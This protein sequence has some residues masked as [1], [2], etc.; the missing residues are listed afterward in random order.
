MAGMRYPGLY[1]DSWQHCL[2]ATER[3]PRDPEALLIP[4]SKFVFAK[5]CYL[6]SFYSICIAVIG[7]T[8]GYGA[9]VS[10]HSLN[11]DF[12]GIRN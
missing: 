5:R 8:A 1:M 12:L 2:N 10:D 7:G 11:R 6:N 3:R 9:T 4:A